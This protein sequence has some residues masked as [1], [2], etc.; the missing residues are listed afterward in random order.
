MEWRCIFLLVFFLVFHSVI[1]ILSILFLYL[2]LLLLGRDP[3]VIIHFCLLCACACVCAC[4][5]VQTLVTRYRASGDLYI[6]VHFLV[7]LFVVIIIG[8]GLGSVCFFLFYRIIVNTLFPSGVIRHAGGPKM[9]C[10][11]RIVVVKDSQSYP[12]TRIDTVFVSVNCIIHP[13]HSRVQLI[14][15]PVPPQSIEQ[16]HACIGV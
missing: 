1:E 14:K 15:H 5:I 16:R 9:A 2:L 8:R 13:I 7:T 10:P 4:C 3:E 11:R 6:S 12:V